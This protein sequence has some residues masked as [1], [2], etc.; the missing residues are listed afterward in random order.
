MSDTPGLDEISK[1]LVDKNPWM[2]DPIISGDRATYYRWWVA[3][4]PSHMA[5]EIFVQRIERHRAPYVPLEKWAKD[6][7]PYDDVKTY[8]LDDQGGWNEEPRG[9]E[10][11]MRFNR[12]AALT[13]DDQLIHVLAGA[14]LPIDPQDIAESM[15]AFARRLVLGVADSLARDPWPVP[16]SERGP[17]AD[18]GLRDT[19]PVA[20]RG[21]MGD[22]D[23]PEK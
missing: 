11:D 16:L 13:L 18:E 17:H 6:G 7:G 15:E 22:A 3:Y 4:V 9:N 21:I 12:P 19:T 20:S 2:T 1:A 23:E 14:G 5:Y 8:F 10:G